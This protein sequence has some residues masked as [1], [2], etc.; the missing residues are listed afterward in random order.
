MLAYYPLLLQMMGKWAFTIF[1]NAL[2]PLL[3]NCPSFK[4]KLVAGV[5]YRLIH[6]CT[7]S[8]VDC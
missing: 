1:Q 3:S 6:V 2:V 8:Q 5:F 7:Y 4:P